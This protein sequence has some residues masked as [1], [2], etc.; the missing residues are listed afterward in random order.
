MPR[1]FSADDQIIEHARVWTDRLPARHQ[2][3]GPHV[4]ED[5]DHEVWVYEGTKPPPWD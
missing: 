1:L 5:G 2:D 4:E 3:S